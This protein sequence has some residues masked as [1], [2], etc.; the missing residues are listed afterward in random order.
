MNFKNERLCHSKA[1][2]GGSVQIS[3]G[4]SMNPF[5]IKNKQ[6]TKNRQTKRATDGQED[7]PTNRLTKIRR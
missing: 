1:N 7:E 3:L 5:I 4:P 6:K 2:F